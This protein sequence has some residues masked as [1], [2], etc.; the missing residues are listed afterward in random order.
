VEHGGILP[1][2]P[3]EGICGTLEAGLSAVSEE[4]AGEQTLDDAAAFARC[5][6][7]WTLPAGPVLT[8]VGD[9]RIGGGEGSDLRSDQELE[10]EAPLSRRLSLKVALEW[11]YDA[12]PP[13]GYD[14]DDLTLGV[15]FAPALPASG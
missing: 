8:W 9:V 2:G 5:E 12:D 4:H 3:A 1:F 13:A 14:H 15:T 10:L 7:R 6:M 11:R